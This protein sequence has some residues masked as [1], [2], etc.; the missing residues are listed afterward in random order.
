MKS[1]ETLPGIIKAL[2]PLVMAAIAFVLFT[3]VYLY[4]ITRSI[5]PHYA[6][7]LIFAVPFVSFGIVAAFTWTGKIEPGVSATL[8]G[9][10]IF[11]LGA[12]MLL[13]FFCRVI[14]ESTSVTTDVGKY[15]RVLKLT[16]YP[17]NPL[18]RY[19]PKEIPDDAEDV[20]FN[21]YPAFNIELKY[22]TDEVRIQ[23]Y[24]SRFSQLARWHGKAG[25]SEAEK[26]GISFGTFLAFGYPE[27]P[28]DFTVFLLYGRPYRPN[29]WNHG[30]LSLVAIS[31][32]RNEIIYHAEDW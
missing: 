20:L 10:L 32:E 7:N 9:V 16:G 24:V 28:E 23:K 30:E 11:A 12:V 5:D 29:D 6:G 4:L 21:Y 17:V 27:L 31:E 1:N 2:F 19:Y 15:E 3:A 25:G 8:T 22:S 13:A 26:H 14:D 18:T